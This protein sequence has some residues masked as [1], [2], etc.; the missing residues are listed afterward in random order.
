MQILEKEKIS[1]LIQI[2][3]AGCAKGQIFQARRLFEGLLCADSELVGA[4]IG[5][6]FSYIVVDDFDKADQILDELLVSHS[7]DADVK[8]MKVFSLALQKKSEEAKKLAS[9]VDASQQSAYNLCQDALNL[10]DR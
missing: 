8:A 5:L 3:F 4:K 9:S 10:L 6:A 7:D 1:A 2:G